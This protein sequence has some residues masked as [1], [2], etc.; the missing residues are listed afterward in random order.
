MPHVI[1]SS[2]YQTH[3][4]EAW[5]H[6]I[7]EDPAYD[8]S[9][10]R[11]EVLHSWARSRDAKVNPHNVVQEILPAPKLA[12]KI[13]EN[14]DLI[15]VAKSYML[16]LYSIINDT[17]AYLLLCDQDCYV[18]DYIGENTS[19][20]GDFSQTKLTA[21]A[22]RKETVAGTNSIGT[23]LFLRRPIQLVGHEHYL[24]KHAI[25]TCSC[26]PIFNND[27][28][29]I[30]AINIT[31]PK[32]KAHPH[33]LGMVVSAADSIS[34]ELT[35]RQTLEK[36]TNISIQRNTI[37]ENMQS[38]L[39]LLSSSYHVSQI[40]SSALR[41]LNLS[42]DEVMGDNLF[43]FISIDGN[44]FTRNRYDILSK[45][46]YNEEA[47]VNLTNSSLAPKKYRISVNFIKNQYDNITGYLLRFNEVELINKLV[48]KV[49]GFSAHYTFDNIIGASACMQKT[50]TTAEKATNNLSNVLI[51]G[52]SGTGKELIAHAI[53][54]AGKHSS[55]PFVAINCAAIPNNLVESELFGYE[56][57]AFTGADKN[58]RPGK[59][60][61]AN[62]GTIFLDEIGDMPLSIQATIL[63]VIQTKE[64]VRIGGKYPKPIDVRI[65]AA[66]NQNLMELIEQKSFRRDLYYR[67]NIFTINLPN[68]AQRGPS[69]IRLLTDYFVSLQNKNSPFNL[70][71]SPEV[72]RLLENYS[73]PGNVRQLENVVERAVNLVDSDGIITIAQ[74][75]DD[76]LH[77]KT[78]REVTENTPVAVSFAD[79]YPAEAPARTE[80]PTSI[81]NPARTENPARIETPVPQPWPAYASPIEPNKLNMRENEKNLIISALLQS[82]GNVT[83]ASKIL[84][85]NI[86]TLYRK[87]KKYELDVSE[88][89]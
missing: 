21:G 49:S 30:G 1:N 80:T 18:L 34:K 16:R 13:E 19:I 61:M 57:G 11:P 15:S 42:K 59:F 55:G 9:Y 37:I 40:N 53:H 66:T 74:L 63:R 58:G 8:Y 31:M 20:I 73:W 35:L 65:I 45:E 82:N 23:A 4:E 76:I 7:E 48:K 14:R 85:V 84:S 54:N 36:V 3:V 10:V 78:E 77:D 71:V 87:L 86:R 29:I 38:G 46:C 70:T 52:E 27:N 81:E 17:N 60:E 2:E 6:F 51:L 44:T 64:V 67:L 5:H 39:I 72:Y 24:Q 79:D 33:T 43:N 89:R 41:M 25:Y 12:R 62:G 32:E 50:I 28:E 75:P 69:D 88:F 56:K 68:L 22:C 26:S 83:Q 47:S